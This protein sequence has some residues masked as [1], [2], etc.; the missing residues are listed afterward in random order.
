MG[1][2]GGGVWKTTDGGV[3]WSNVSDGFF[4]AG[5]MGA[6]AVAV[7]DA[8]VVYAG[9]GS[10]CIRGNVSPG[11]GLYKS[12]D[13]GSTWTHG[14]L[15]DAGQIGRIQVHP[16]DANLVYVAALGHAFG[17]NP[18]RGV[19][20]SKDGG[21]SWEKVLYVNESTGAVD[22]A[23][24]AFNPRV[25]YAAMWRAERKPWAILSGGEEGGVF[26]SADSGDT[27]KKLKGGLPEGIVG[28]IGVAVSPANPSRVWAL[29]EAEEGGLFR[30][31]DAGTSW[32]LVNPE[33]SFRQRAWYY[34]HVYADPRDED[35]VYVL[36]TG[37]Y[38]SID[39][40]KSF[41]LIPV[42]H[43]D[44]HDLW[45]NP[46]DPRVMIESNDGGANVSYNGGKSWSPQLNQPTAE[47]YRVTVD[48]Q[49]LYRVYG[50]QQDNSTISV[51]S[52]TRS[53]GI[54]LQHWMAVG[55]GESGHIAVDPRDP[56][57]TYAGSYGGTIDRVNHK[58]GHV[59]SVMVYPQ[60]ALGNRARD[61]R[62]RFQ[63]NAPIR[64]SP[65]DPDVVYQT[66]QYV[67]KSTNGG[68]S[69]EAVSP[70][71]T[72]NDPEKQDFPGQPITNDATGVEVYDVIFAF[73]E[74]LRE[75]GVLWAG[76]DDGL[77]H[78]SKD[79]GKSWKNVTPKGLPEWSTVN[80]IEI[81]AH[82]P[83]RVFIAAYRYRNDDFKPYIFRT[84]DYGESWSLL[85]DG[86]N[87]IPASHFTRVVREDP[88]RKGLLYAGTEFGLYA[89]FDDGLHWQ[90]FQLNLPVTPVT[91]LKVHRQDLVVATQGR[92]FWILD[93]VTPLHAVNEAARS[94]AYL[95][96]PRDVHRIETGEERGGERSSGV[97]DRLLAAWIPRGWVGDNPP[98]GAVI[99]TYFTGK[100]T[101]DVSYEILDA[102]GAVVRQEK[103]AAKPGMNRF[104]WDLRYPGPEILKGAIL[105]GGG[106]SGPRAVPGAYQVRVRSGAWS[107]TKGFR[108]L[109]D[110]ELDVTEAD[111]EEQFDFLVEVR[112]EI[113]KTHAAIGRLRDVK[114]QAGAIAE[115]VKSEEITKAAKSLE[116][117]L[118]AIEDELIQR[119]SKSRQDPINFPG[120]LDNQLVYLYGV[121]GE[122][123]D[124]P[125][126]GAR[127]R[128]TDLRKEVESQLSR[129]EEVLKMEVASFNGLVRQKDVPAIFVS[130]L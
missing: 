30:S 9:T 32:S 3:N 77:V 42:P 119:K 15:R 8:N 124:K 89:S 122:Q 118:T 16:Q 84:N 29:V 2:T 90:S 19:F 27:W 130:G 40:G 43:G 91:D 110:P 98:S 87:G 57:I 109:K 102:S 47:F 116:E 37:F 96:A 7:S 28:R 85:T 100:P 74:S 67:H 115:R 125:T 12:V 94:E 99:Y 73:E 55:G 53:G 36:N 76:S 79:G 5:S 34:T 4:E 95:F 1:S 88:D 52:R 26:K 33:R 63:W 65:H 108:V 81:S 129:L 13:A 126:A 112:D 64:I 60:M 69:W 62:Y 93:D 11:V 75:K 17:P 72:R 6:I 114:A 58:T 103:V 127:E 86:R 49:F 59:R 39:G 92:S 82:A 48:D 38:K 20:R 71:L 113:T 23:M 46:D 44:N 61:L 22:L 56:S 41:G 70:D 24:D 10:A 83:G 31:E 107:E 68:Q 25:L 105:W 106:T 104:V 45:L 128:F 50:P 54:T 18:E 35:T 111:L 97:R 14:G 21:K 78:L 123:D 117:K 51:P 121:A 101:E 80:A 66:S 120:K